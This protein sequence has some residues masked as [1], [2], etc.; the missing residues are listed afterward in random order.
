[1]KKGDYMILL[2]NI[3][4]L[5]QEAGISLPKLEKEL[6]FSH[7]SIYNWDK[8]SPSIDKIQKIAKYFGKSLDFIFYGFEQSKF[9]DTVNDIRLGMSYE[10]FAESTG[11]DVEDIISICEGHISNPPSIDIIR[12]L[13]CCD[14]SLGE[15]KLFKLAGYDIDEKEMNFI[16]KKDYLVEIANNFLA[17]GY[18]VTL[19][20]ES[21]DSIYVEFNAVPEKEIGRISLKK[22]RQLTKDLLKKNTSINENEEDWDEL[23]R[24]HIKIYK[25]FLKILREMDFPSHPDPD[26][27][28]QHPISRLY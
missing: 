22:F 19:S 13:V 12:K 18:R 2:D 4:T 1:M 5:C 23:E 15:S 6:G 9:V 11:I 24:E 3:K 7:G 20:T 17:V 8:S 21:R 14:Y 10:E 28:F 25:I 16:P 26:M 27:N